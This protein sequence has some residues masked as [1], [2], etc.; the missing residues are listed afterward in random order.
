MYQ[1][2]DLE[3]V[4]FTDFASGVNQTGDFDVSAYFAHVDVGYKMDKW[5]FTYTGWYHSG[6]GNDQD[7]DFESFLQT[8]IDVPGSVV[9]LGS[10][11]ALADDDVFTERSQIL[12]KGYIM[13]RLSAGYQATEKLYLEAAAMYMLTAED[14]E[15]V[16]DNAVSQSNDEIGF[17][18]DLLGKY[19][20]YKNL[21]L[22]LQFGYLFADDAMDVFEVTRDGSSDE[23]LYLIESWLRFKF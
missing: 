1:G 10:G 15:Y 20:L 4:D 19:Q 14:I 3:D 2:G 13:N 17:E 22:A 7:G 21:E 9:I 8:D 18:I 6:D 16:D 11:Q 5:K 12:D 23:D